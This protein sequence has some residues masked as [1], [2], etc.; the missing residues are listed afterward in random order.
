VT[1]APL[2]VP[3][4]VI[5]CGCWALYRLAHTPE[6]DRVPVMGEMIGKALGIYLLYAMGAAL[7][8]AVLML[9]FLGG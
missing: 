6:E 1:L 7:L 8:F 9:A 3:A 5:G 2:F 4:L